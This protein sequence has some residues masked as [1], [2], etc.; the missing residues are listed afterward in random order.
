MLLKNLG[1]E[2][3]FSILLRRWLLDLLA[4]FTSLLK[5]DFKRARAIIAGHNWLLLHWKQIREKR[6]AVQQLR[7]FSDKALF[8]LFYPKSIALQYFL[9]GRKTFT[10]LMKAIGRERLG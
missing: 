7:Q 8:K 6:K 10:A 9:K 4:I 3:L 1:R 2:H 5:F